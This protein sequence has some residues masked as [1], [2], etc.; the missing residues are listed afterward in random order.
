[1]MFQY[2]LGNGNGKFGPANNVPVGGFTPIYVVTTD[3]NGDDNLDLVT[4]NANSDNVSI[5]LG[6]DN[7]TF[8][9]AT[10]L[11]NGGSTS[12]LLHSR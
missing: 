10:Y 7:G 6:N 9:T 12:S 5:L 3:F 4:A 2:S 8:D 11:C 1:M